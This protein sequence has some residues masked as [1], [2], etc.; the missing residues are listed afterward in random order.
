MIAQCVLD[1]EPDEK[2]TLSTLREERGGRIDEMVASQLRTNVWRLTLS[3]VAGAFILALIFA[4]A[5]RQIP[6]PA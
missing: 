4:F 1:Y 2:I 3:L 5:I 6:F